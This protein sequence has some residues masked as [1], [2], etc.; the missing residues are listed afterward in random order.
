MHALVIDVVSIARAIGALADEVVFVGGSV[1]PLLHTERVLAGVR[2]TKDVD[3]IVA[4]A[5]YGDVDRL[6]STLRAQGFT[7][8][9]DTTAHMHRWRSPAQILFDLVP[10]GKHPGGTGSDWDA[11][12]LRSPVVVTIN[13]VTFRH[14]TAAVFIAMKLEAYSDRGGG[15]VHA[16]HDIEDV[17]A[18]MASR[19]SI[20]DDVR[21][22]EPKVR[23]N[24]ARFAATLVASEIAEDILTGHL[25]NADDVGYAVRVARDRLEA[26]AVILP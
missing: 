22:A 14:V 19:P 10:A 21:V 18:L 25:N 9:T 7:H 6:A 3:G 11:L 4:S 15:N 24:I 16:S 5:S 1:A 8:V 2:A 20:V 23:K 17:I 12:A 26:I 13:G